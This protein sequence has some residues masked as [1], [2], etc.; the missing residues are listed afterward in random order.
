MKQSM[1]VLVTG[2]S[3]GIGR[4]ICESLSRRGHV[5]AAS[6]RNV[7]ELEGITASMKL[8]IDVTDEAS[9]KRSVNRII[10]TYGK[11]DVL[12]NN[13]GYSM[14]GA[15]EEV[16][17]DKIR[18][19]FDVNVFGI[20]RMTQ[21]VLPSM[22]Q[23]RAGR[24]I[25]IGSVSGQFAQSLNGGYC[26]SKYAVEALS[27]TL[28]ME[29]KE[30]GIQ[31]TVIE[32]GP[33]QT[34]FFQKL[35]EKSGDL[36]ANAESPYRK[37]YLK[38]INYRQKQQRMDSLEAAQKMCR[39]LMRDKLKPRYKIAVPLK[40]RALLMLPDGVSEYFLLRR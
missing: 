1:V 9:V 2:C 31:T 5:V 30:F 17:S 28:R 22:R 18:D 10:E 6:A 21:A 24:I 11:I 32:P 29:L 39:I 20:I 19:M 4:N 12:I 13:A 7:E 26:A 3:S 33:M 23:Q 38:D 35:A 8:K 36:M 37:F 14:R 34:G 25:N 27:D 40:F 15:L 16:N